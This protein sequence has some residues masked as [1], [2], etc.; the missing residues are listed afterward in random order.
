MGTVPE[1]AG[2]VGDR[3]M[4]FMKHLTDIAAIKE[5]SEQLEIPLPNLESLMYLITESDFGEYLWLKSGS[6]FGTEKYF[7]RSCAPELE[8]VSLTEDEEGKGGLTSPGEELS[9]KTG[10]VILASVLKEEKVPGIRWRGRASCEDDIIELDIEGDF[11]GMTVPVHIGIT[12][13]SRR[14]APEPLRREL[15]PFLENG[16]TVSYLQYP[17]ESVLA[18]FVFEIL[19]DTEMMPL[20]RAYDITY[21]ILSSEPVYGRHMRDLLLELCRE[22]QFPLEPERVAEI[23]SYREYA[24]MKKRWGK[25]LRHQKRKSPSWEEMMDK[26]SAFLPDV[27]KAI[28]KDELFFGDW[29][30]ELG[31][32]LD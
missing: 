30:P 6:V 9:V 27:W 7:H 2:A 29:M 25:Y 24:Y 15:G 5:K 19:R 4:N 13:M 14:L 3:S 11:A 21:R 28:C 31:R 26:L 1:D 18:E 23:L 16:R 12:E 22:E 20:M 17:S 10:Y 32:Y 8:F